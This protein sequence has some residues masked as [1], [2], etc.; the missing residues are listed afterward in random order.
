MTHRRSA[1]VLAA[2]MFTA[3]NANPVDDEGELAWSVSPQ[4]VDAEVG[5]PI[6][7]EITSLHDPSAA[8]EEGYR[9]LV[10][11]A[12]SDEATI[13]S[14]SD[15]E[16]ELEGGTIVR[17]C[18]KAGDVTLAF[19]IKGFPGQSNKAEVQQ[20]TAEVRCVDE[21]GE[22]GAGGEGGTGGSGGDGGAGAAGGMGGAGG[23]GSSPCADEMEPNDEPGQA[24]DLG[25]LASGEAACINLTNSGYDEDFI[26][27]DVAAGT[28]IVAAIDG[29][30]PGDT[31]QN[32]TLY[33]DQQNLLNTSGGAC[34]IVVQS[35]QPLDAGTYYLRVWGSVNPGTSYAFVQAL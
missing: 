11:V 18:K 10:D 13:D 4:S 33:D 24:D 2:V 1:A 15:E 16:I 34:P 32:V 29:C 12:S 23:G 14:Q 31:V 28:T 8:A 22:G 7:F 9:V 21:L 17:T 26:A 3:C 20:A 5:S 19:S 25:T 6:L 35:P 30:D 27:F